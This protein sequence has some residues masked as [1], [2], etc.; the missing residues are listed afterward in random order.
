[1]SKASD[2]MEQ[3]MRSGFDLTTREFFRRTLER[4]LKKYGVRA[5]LSDADYRELTIL[6]VSQCAEND[7]RELGLRWEEDLALK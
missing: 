4:L 1:M 6:I 5:A 2:A 7:I 3:L